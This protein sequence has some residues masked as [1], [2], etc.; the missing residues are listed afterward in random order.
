MDKK[1][2]ILKRF[3]LIFMRHL[4]IFLLNSI[5]NVLICSEVIFIYD[6]L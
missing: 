4:S 2:V 3:N 1:I 6:I 5:D